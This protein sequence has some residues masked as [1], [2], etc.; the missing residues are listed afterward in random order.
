MSRLNLKLDLDR[1]ARG[2]A[3][4]AALCAML[5]IAAP[6]LAQAPWPNRPIRILNGGGPGSPLDIFARVFAQRLQQELGQPIVTDNRPGANQL[7]VADQCSKSPPDGYTFCMVSQ[8][9]LTNNPYMFKK[10]PYDVEKGFTPVAMLAT[11]ISMILA[12]S[13][14]GAGS[15]QDVVKLSRQQPRTINWGSYGIGSASHL[16]LESIRSETG[17][18][19]THVPF[20]D[21]VQALQALQR[22]DVQLI[23]APP[24]A[25][26][27]PHIASGEIVPLVFG[28]VERHPAY[29]NVPTFAEAGLGAYF[30]RGIWGILGPPGLPEDIVQKMNKASNAAMQDSSFVPMMNTLSL[31]KRTGTPAEMAQA[32]RGV[33]A[34]L[35]PAF[36][37]ANIEPN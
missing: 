29:P 32:Y 17:W 33:R 7:I 37:R 20:T 22:N 14:L 3:A 9:P 21:P 27:S 10:L 24:N 31:A 19:V 28:G 12:N 36:K 34:Q 26:I 25:Q 16:Y 4:F 13:R 11:P 35:G 30:V 1:I 6:A 15:I 18:D 23:Y 2:I 5:S 8:E